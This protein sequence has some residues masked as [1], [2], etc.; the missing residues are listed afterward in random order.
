MKK[1]SDT[2]L[3][4]FNSKQFSD[5]KIICNDREIPAHRNVLKLMS[6][7]FE[8]MLNS[9]MEESQKG[10]VTIDDIEGNVVFEMVRFMYTGEVE[11][12]K[13]YVK[14]LL[15]A[16]EKY[17]IEKLKE[18]CLESLSLYL[19]MKNVAETLTLADRYNA[20]ILI[21]NCVGLIKM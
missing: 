17:G 3:E 20:D 11:N 19:N 18:K 1:S 9:G 4:F 16:A 14:D 8:A 6:P 21:Q 12:V 15:D 13:D 10:E 7:V 5:F 2:V